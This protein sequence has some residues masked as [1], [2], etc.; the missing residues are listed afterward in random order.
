MG[1]IIDL[2]KCLAVLVIAVVIGVSAVGNWMT[3]GMQGSIALQHPD[4]FMLGGVGDGSDSRKSASLCQQIRGLSSGQK[5]LCMLY[6]DHMMHV[7]RGASTGISECQYQFK[8]RKWNCSTVDDSTV[9]G[10]ILSIPSKEA[11]FANAV[12]SAGVVH[13]ISR[14]CRDGQLTS[15]GCSDARRPRDL[16]KEWIWGGC[17]DNIHY[18]YKF[19]KNFID[20]REREDSNNNKPAVGLEVNDINGDGGGDGGGVIEQKPLTESEEHGR[21]LMNLHNNEAGR[22]AVIKNMKVT[23]KCHG[24]SGSCSLVTCWQQL[25]P[26]RKVGDHLQGAYDEATRV[27]TT[28][29]GRLKVKRRNTNIPTANDLVFLQKSPNY[30][31]QNG[32]IGSMGT[33]GRVCLPNARPSDARSC[34][35]MCCGRGYT[36]MKTKIKERCKCKFHWCCY[37]ECQ[38][39]TKNVELTLC[40]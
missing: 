28:K 22:R 33:H 37:V 38:T 10:P 25:A 15:C 16:R 36:T 12:A 27:K 34:A 9:F 40:K 8:D 7:G 20:I 39:C 17:G 30:C 35:Q 31:H 1:V 23:C 11:A 2:M 24:V 19:A 26:F 3:L 5:K 6:T 21:K 13:S 4:L 14:G 18:G 32:T 29:K